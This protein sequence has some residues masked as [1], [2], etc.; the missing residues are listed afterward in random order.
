MVG[1]ISNANW[2]V[3]ASQITEASIDQLVLEFLEYP[4]LHRVEHSIHAR[5]Y[6]ILKA[7][8][9][10]D[11]TFPLQTGELTQPIHKEWPET[12]SRPN[13]NGRRGN[14]DLA[15]LSPDGIAAMSLSQFEDGECDQIKP[16][17]VIEMGLHYGMKHL[18]DD[19]EKLENSKVLHAYI[20]HLVRRKHREIAFSNEIGILNKK[21]AELKKN[22]S[23]IKVAFAA[24]QSDK[25]F[26]K[27]LGEDIIKAVK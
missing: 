14:F 3:R 27:L 16:P 4:Y 13:K 26:L 8:P 9:H 25:K 10:F 23:N 17:I 2:V 22:N 7:Q 12:E 15:V 21:I 5:L 19:A 20:V 11:H 6:G 18:S 1:A 24:V